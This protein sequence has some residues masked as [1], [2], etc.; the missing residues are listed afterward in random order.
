VAEL[1]NTPYKEWLG[2]GRG[3]KNKTNTDLIFKGKD[4]TIQITGVDPYTVQ[5]EKDVGGTFKLTFN[6]RELFDVFK[7]LEEQHTQK[8][9]IK[10]DEGGLMAISWEDKVGYFAVHQ[11]MVNAKGQPITRRLA[12]MR[13]K[14][15]TE[16]AE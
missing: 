6:S 1:I 5:L 12:P 11:P 7:R 13:V 10:G 16:A 15:A 4:L 3:D 14:A 8:F 2:K 9:T